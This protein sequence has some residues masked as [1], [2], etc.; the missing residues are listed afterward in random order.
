MKKCLLIFFSII[1]QICLVQAEPLYILNEYCT[2]N[3]YSSAVAA[4]SHC[5]GV[6]IKRDIRG[7]IIRIPFENPEYNFQKITPQLY[8]KLLC[9][10]YF[11]AKI[12][13]PVI[14]EVHTEKIPEGINMKN[15]WLRGIY[16]GYKYI[17]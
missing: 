7:I 9:I 17:K 14:I 8:E 13:N 5:D 4:L 3:I 15:G 6:A 16:A 1:F 10:E 2:N 12:K 11:L